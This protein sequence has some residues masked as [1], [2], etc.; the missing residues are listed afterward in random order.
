[1]KKWIQ[2][3]RLAQEQWKKIQELGEVKHEKESEEADNR[4]NGQT[5]SN[6]NRI[7]RNSYRIELMII[8]KML[9]YLTT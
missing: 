2:K 6:G 1:M 3:K 9:Y 5:W 4:A 7:Y 8:K